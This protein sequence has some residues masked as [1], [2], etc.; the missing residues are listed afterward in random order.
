MR[1]AAHGPQSPGSGER[2][3]RTGSCPGRARV[4]IVRHRCWTRGFCISGVH[5]SSSPTAPV[6]TFM[7]APVK[8][9]HGSC[10]ST[11]RRLPPDPRASCNCISS[12][13]WSPTPVIGSSSGAIHRC[14]PSAEGC[15]LDAH[16][17]K[18]KRF[19]SEVSGN[20]WNASFRATLHRP[21][22]EEACA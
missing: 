4:L 15:V 2:R 3:D 20:V 21:V 14:S 5:R 1:G 17:E 19:Q 9:L 7:W 16:P 18:H 8:L 12:N 22:L 6:S 13:R 11:G 10:C